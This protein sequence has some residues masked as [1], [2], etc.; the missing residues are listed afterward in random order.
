MCE[1]GLSFSGHALADVAKYFERTLL[2]N[3]SPG[4]SSAS[5]KMFGEDRPSLCCHIQHNM[6]C[7]P[8]H[9]WHS[10]N[11]TSPR[12]GFSQGENSS[13][14]TVTPSFLFFFLFASQS[15]RTRGLG[16]RKE[17]GNSTAAKQEEILSTSGH[18]NQ[19]ANRATLCPDVPVKKIEGGVQSRDS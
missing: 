18:I 3:M 9:N 17:G 12:G 2:G 19:T 5:L 13:E 1:F 15:K 16:R 14:N 6:P 10:E 8:Q 11:G 7:Q 4:A